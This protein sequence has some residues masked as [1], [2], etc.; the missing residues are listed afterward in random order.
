MPGII[1]EVGG[2]RDGRGRSR[3]MARLLVL[4]SGEKKEI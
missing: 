2:I 3:E 1:Y 4:A